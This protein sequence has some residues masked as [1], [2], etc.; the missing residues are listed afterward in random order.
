MEVKPWAASG[1]DDFF[2]RWN[3]LIPLNWLSRL[4][5]HNNVYIIWYILWPKQPYLILA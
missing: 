2:L 4:A 1:G 5:G 3:T